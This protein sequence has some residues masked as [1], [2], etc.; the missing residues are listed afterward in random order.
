MFHRKPKV[1]PPVKAETSV[2]MQSV[3]TRLDAAASRI[4][5][6]RS[7]YEERLQNTRRPRKIST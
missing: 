1:G 7:A 5:R 4:D 3:E 2:E 6:E